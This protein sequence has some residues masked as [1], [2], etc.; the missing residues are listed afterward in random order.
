M[1]LEHVGAAVLR[2]F[3]AETEEVL[4]D[5]LRSKTGVKPRSP[6]EDD[7]HARSKRP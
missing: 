2:L 1:P 3:E 4:H 5:S 7:G 6:V